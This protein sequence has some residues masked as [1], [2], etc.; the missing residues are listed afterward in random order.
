[1]GFISSMKKPVKRGTLTSRTLPEPLLLMLTAIFVC[2]TWF[3]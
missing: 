2:T 1:M 3:R